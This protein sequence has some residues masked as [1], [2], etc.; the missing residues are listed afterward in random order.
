M[1]A[2]LEKNDD[3][4]SGADTSAN[5]GEHEEAD[6]LDGHL[7]RAEIEL[8]YALMEAQIGDDPQRIALVELALATVQSCRRGERP[9]SL[10]PP[11]E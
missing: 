2:S 6:L 7:F 1:M 3:T 10:P 9:P 11:E 8:H 5:P 4:R